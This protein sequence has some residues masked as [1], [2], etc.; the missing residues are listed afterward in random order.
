MKIPS[1]PPTNRRSKL[2]KQIVAVG[3]GL[4]YDEWN[5]D[6]DCSHR[7][8]WSCEDCPWQIEINKEKHEKDSTHST[9]TF[10]F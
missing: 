8:G 3:C 2:Y 6:Y 5:G 10:E 9:G 1:T 7:Y 4:E